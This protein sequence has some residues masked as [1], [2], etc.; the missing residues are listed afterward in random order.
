M[1]YYL[2]HAEPLAVVSTINETKFNWRCFR[3]EHLTRLILMAQ[4][5]P[6]MCANAPV[7]CKVVVRI[8]TQEQLAKHG[9]EWLDQNAEHHL[10]CA[11]L[12]R[13]HDGLTGNAECK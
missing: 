2:A 6:I 7:S 13:V 12:V 10:R 11:P 3:P 4:S 1:L 5:V 8:L 9:V